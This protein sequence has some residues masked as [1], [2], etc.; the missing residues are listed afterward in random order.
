M[1]DTLTQ[2]C[3]ELMSNALPLLRPTANN[4]NGIEPETDSYQLNE[5]SNDP[6]NLIK[7]SF[8]GY[9]LGWSLAKFGSLNLELPQAFWSRLCGGIEYVY[10]L[11]DLRSQDAI[12]ANHLERIL[13]T[14][15]QSTDEEFSAV[16]GDYVFNLELA[17]CSLPIELCQDGNTKHLTKANAA[18]YVDLYLEAFTKVDALQ[19][20]IVYHAIEDVATHKIMS[21]LTPENAKRRM[22]AVSII[23]VEAFKAQTTIYFQGRKFNA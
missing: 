20:K 10:T 15:N 5:E 13:S 12:M 2:I 8:F 3:N 17:S 6:V 22:C 19:F 14:S 21:M 16:Y 9:M 4:T 23:N 11:K 18:E 7:L 1:R